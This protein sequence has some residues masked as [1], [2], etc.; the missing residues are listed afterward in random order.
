VPA[1]VYARTY[2]EKLGLW[3]ALSKKV[4]PSASVRLALAAVENGVADAAVVYR[5]DIA[6]A[7][8]VSL[9]LAIPV[10]EG[11]RIVYPA[12]VMRAG[13]NREAAVRLLTWLSGADAAGTFRAAGFIPVSH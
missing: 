13:R 10:A 1:G 3:G 11:P 4:V 2:L 12:A 5:T 7:R 9:A 8:R 6:S